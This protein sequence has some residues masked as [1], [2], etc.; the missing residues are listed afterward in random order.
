MN[1]NDTV[2]RMVSQK[3]I[4]RRFSGTRVEVQL[5][6]KPVKNPTVWVS[7]GDYHTNTEGSGPVRIK[8]G[9]ELMSEAMVKVFR[10]AGADIR[11]LR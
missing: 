4:R 9:Q 10:E 6:K 2:A 3:I 11:P 8:Y 7:M 5:P 1:E